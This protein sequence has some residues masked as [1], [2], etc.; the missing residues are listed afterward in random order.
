[1]L[2]S[3]RGRALLAASATGV[4]PEGLDATGDPLYCRAWT[5]LGVPCLNLPLSQGANGLP[6]GVQLITDRWQDQQ[7]L[8]I[9]RTLMIKKMP[10]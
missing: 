3:H 9:A 7:L 10:K 5:L 1:M 2:R 6:V 8:Q 4:A